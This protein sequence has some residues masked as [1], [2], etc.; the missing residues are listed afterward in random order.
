MFNLTDLTQA[1]TSGANSIGLAIVIA[2]LVLMVGM[3]IAALI[4]ARR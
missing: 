2:A 1:L 4:R 3:V